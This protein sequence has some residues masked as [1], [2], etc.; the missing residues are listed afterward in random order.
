MM[1]KMMSDGVP[2]DSDNVVRL[3]ED[4]PNEETISLLET[5]LQKAQQG[6][7]IGL[8]VS[9]LTSDGGVVNSHTQSV[10]EHIFTMIGS[11]RFQEQVLLE[12]IKR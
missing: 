2:G 5:L 10:E 3:C 11:V 12:K 6:E 8:V 9:G 4:F 7:L 1:V